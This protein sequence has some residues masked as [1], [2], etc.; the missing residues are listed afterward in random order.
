[1]REG[2]RFKGTLTPFS[3]LLAY[4]RLATSALK[5]RQYQRKRRDHKVSHY[6]II[7][8]DYG[9][10]GRVDRLSTISASCGPG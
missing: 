4:A 6:L 10:L 7:P 8:W 9:E 2:F 1:M 5:K 3:P